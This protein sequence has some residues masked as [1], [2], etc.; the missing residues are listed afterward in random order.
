MAETILYSTDEIN[1]RLGAIQD[2][3]QDIADVRATALDSYVTET[4]VGASVASF[5][6]GADSLPMKS[7]VADIEA[8][9]YGTGAPTTNNI[10][11]IVGCTE[12]K[13]TAASKNLLPNY[14]T[15]GGGNDLTW[16]V[17]A[18]GSVTINGTATAR[19]YIDISAMSDHLERMLPTGSY[20]LSGCPVGGGDSSFRF[21]M[22]NRLD[23]S[24]TS[25]FDYDDGSGVDFNKTERTTMLRAYIIVV[26]GATL[27]DVTFYPMVRLASDADATYEPYSGVTYTFDWSAEAGTIYG[28]T[29]DVKTGLLTVTRFC[30]ALK[31]DETFNLTSATRRFTKG[32]DALGFPEAKNG[33]TSENPANAIGS[34]SVYVTGSTSASNFPEFR[35][36]GNNLAF[37]DPQSVCATV[38][39]FQ[40]FLTSQHNNGTPL[41]ICYDLATP[42]TYQL[43][44]TEVLTLLGRNAIYNGA[45]KVNLTYRAD[46]TIIY[47]KLKA[48]I[49]SLGGSV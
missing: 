9:Q 35:I 1:A 38:P 45:G 32:L 37:Y 14:L 28:C 8:A 33:T 41:Q 27:N 49:V 22:S 13:I 19:T 47:D 16:V 17:N 34:H 2:V 11:K 5:D 26:S 36:Y 15:S 46:S 39:A 48:A 30:F 10:R 42:I 18:D 3:V 6:D 43:T 4:I 29:L 20:T 40:S 12:A 21:C 7:F 24:S 31:G 44:P 25:S 23:G